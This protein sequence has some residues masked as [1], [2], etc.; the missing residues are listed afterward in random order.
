M[1]MDKIKT[2]IEWSRPLPFSADLYEDLYEFASMDP[3][4]KRV[5]LMQS[6]HFGGNGR[7]Y[8]LLRDEHGETVEVLALADHDPVSDGDS[9]EVEAALLDFW[10]SELGN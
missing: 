3:V 8:V 5:D 10:A 6:I 2:K 4:D 1:G 7:E 9:L